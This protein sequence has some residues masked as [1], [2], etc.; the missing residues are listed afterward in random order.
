MNNYW[1]ETYSGRRFYSLAPEKNEILIEDIAYSL[2]KICRFMGH[3]KFFY[4]VAEHS[5]LV[6]YLV[7]PELK[8]AALLHD[9]AEA[10]M[11]DMARPWKLIFTDFAAVLEKIQRE[12]FKRFGIDEGLVNSPD[13]E[14]ADNIMLA[15]ERRELMKPIDGWVIKES[16]LYINPV[17]GYTPGAAKSLF[18]KEFGRLIK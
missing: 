15:T 9:A 5:F 16:P 13:I 17:V 4:S 7:E 14:K 6:S 18:M 1:I 2:S 8:L 3:P 11:G 12:I 10:Y